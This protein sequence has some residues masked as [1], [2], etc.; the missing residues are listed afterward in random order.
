V[1]GPPACGLVQIGQQHRRQLSDSSS[2]SDDEDWI[3]PKREFTNWM[4]CSNLLL[5]FDSIWYIAYGHLYKRHNA[6]SIAYVPK[7]CPLMEATDAAR[8]T[9][10]IC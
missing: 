3:P 1:K 4:K 5:L 10:I 6:T 7:M 9:T 2:R 8:R